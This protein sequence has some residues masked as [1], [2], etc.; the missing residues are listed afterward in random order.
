MNYFWQYAVFK[1]IFSSREE[2]GKR[3]QSL[4]ARKEGGGSLNSA[5]NTETGAVERKGGKNSWFGMILC[6]RGAKNFAETPL[7]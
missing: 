5:F 2:R 3:C 1:Y 7:P 6:K 4:E